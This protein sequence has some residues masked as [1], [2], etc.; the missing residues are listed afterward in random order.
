VYMETHGI[1]LACDPVT[2]QLV[3]CTDHIPLHSTAVYAHLQVRYKSLESGDT[4]C[5]TIW[6]EKAGKHAWIQDM[7]AE[8]TAAV[9]QNWIG[10]SPIAS[11][12]SA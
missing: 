10:P 2:Q 9:L 3:R 4:Q 1:F 11:P 6:K 12:S 8:V 7:P 5:A